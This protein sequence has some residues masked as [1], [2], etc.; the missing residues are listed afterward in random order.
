MRAATYEREGRADEVLQV[1]EVDRPA[2]GPGQVLVRVVVAAIN[3]TDVKIRSGATS[4]QIDTF[5]VPLMDGAGVIEAVGA[6]VDENRVGERVWLMLAAHLNRWGAAA[7]YSV[8]PAERA[9]P[10]PAEASFDLGATL[11][12]PAVTAAHC[13]FSDGPLDGRDVLVAGGA[14]AVGRF[15][16]QLAAWS[17]ARV[18]ATVSG[19]AKADVA[20]SA[21]ADLIVNY[22]DADAA[23]QVRAWTD[24]VDRVVELALGPNIDLDLAVAGFG[25]KIVTYAIDGPDPVI[26][27]RRCMYSGVSLRFMLLYALP[28]PVLADAVATVVRAMAD[29]ALT[30]PTATR[31]SLDAIAAAQLAQEAGPF[32]RVLVDIPG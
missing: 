18:A 1:I 21:G 8:V 30:V 3:P 27:V 19:D 6:G 13:L 20:R 9:I 28:A 16:V 14:G 5:Q 7:Q 15:A 31:F 22:R 17:G 4:R 12:V 29:G 2:P 10:L 32:G 11:G 25:T 24:R 26:P 23:D